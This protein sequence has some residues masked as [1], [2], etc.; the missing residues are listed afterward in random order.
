MIR[1]SQL[2]KDLYDISVWLECRY[3]AQDDIRLHVMQ[4]LSQP[5]QELSIATVDTD[6]SNLNI[7][8]LHRDLLDALQA[9]G[10]YLAWPSNGDDPEDVELTNEAAN[11]SHTLQPSID[12]VEQAL[13]Q[14]GKD[15]I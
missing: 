9:L 5:A 3:N 13:F 11:S 15:N 10:H 6:R 12:R 4:A 2:R 14:R 8:H 1:N 7:D